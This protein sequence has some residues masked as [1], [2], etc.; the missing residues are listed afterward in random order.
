MAQAP[1][2]NL[3]TK[4]SSK[5]QAGQLRDEFAEAGKLFAERALDAEF[6]RH[7]RTRAPDAVP[8]QPDMNIVTLNAHKF[9][10]STVGPDGGPHSVQHCFYLF[11]RDLLSI[12]LY[13]HRFPTCLPDVN[14]L[15]SS[16]TLVTAR[17]R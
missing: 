11:G 4:F 12:C 14:G 1:A 8:L 10:I 15:N 5:S 2:I 3:K 6:E 13:R 16:P 17:G 7:H 9:N